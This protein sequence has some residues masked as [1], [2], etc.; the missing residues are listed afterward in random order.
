LQYYKI[1][2]KILDS[3]YGLSPRGRMGTSRVYEPIYTVD[4]LYNS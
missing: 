3:V 1:V 2:I 4:N